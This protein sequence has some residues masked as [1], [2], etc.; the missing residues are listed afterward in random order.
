[1]M[2]I[3]RKGANPKPVK[4]LLKKLDK[5]TQVKKLIEELD[6]VFSIYIR[7]RDIN[8]NGTTSCF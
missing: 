1:M 2:F 3:N 4:N 8:P 6:E 7:T 5:K